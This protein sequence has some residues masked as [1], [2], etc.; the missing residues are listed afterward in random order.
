VRLL[1]A[2][3]ASPAAESQFGTPGQVASES[4][5]DHITELLRSLFRHQTDGDGDN[6]DHDLQRLGLWSLPPVR[7]R[8][9]M[10]SAPRLPSPHLLSVGGGHGQEVV[11]HALSFVAN[12]RDLCSVSLVRSSTDECSGGECQVAWR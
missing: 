10:S 4:R 12:A 5:Q 3:G 1:V 7:R 2:H 9:L 6:D 11:V 8:R